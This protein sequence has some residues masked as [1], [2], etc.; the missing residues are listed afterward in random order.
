M[1]A[2]RAFRLPSPTASAP[3]AH[4]RCSPR[5]TP[6]PRAPGPG[7]PAGLDRARTATG[8]VVARPR[9]HRGPAAPPSPHRCAP[10]KFHRAISRRPSR[11]PQ[12]NR[13]APH[14]EPHA[15][16]PRQPGSPHR[17]AGR[18]APR[19]RSCCPGRLP[20]PTSLPLGRTQR[21]DDPVSDRSTRGR[22]GSRPARRPSGSAVSSQTLRQ[23]LTRG[24]LARMEPWSAG[25]Q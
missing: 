8:G 18:R 13:A 25:P 21:R 1:S 19:R 11:W 14:A 12:S 2:P 23:R 10:K 17:P 15:A 16:Q 6:M 5:P 3:P 20:A 4:P 7:R 22:P 24:L 9:C